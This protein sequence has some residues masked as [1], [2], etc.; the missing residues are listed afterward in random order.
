MWKVANALGVTN[1][2]EGTVRRDGNHLRVSTA[3]VDASNDNM[4]WMESYDRDLTDVL[5][6][7]E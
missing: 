2:L 7:S 6:H 3:L 5:C 4:I 1:V